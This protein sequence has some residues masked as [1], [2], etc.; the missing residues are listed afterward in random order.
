[1][2]DTLYDLSHQIF[3]E[4]T[5]KKPNEV[6]LELTEKVKFPE[7]HD[8]STLNVIIPKPRV[9]NGK[10]FFEGNVFEDYEKQY[11]SIWSLFL[12]S[13]YHLGAHVA[14]SKYTE[15]ENWLRNKTP[16]IGWKVIDYVE[17]LKVE[18][19]L[20]KEFSSAFNNI[21]SIDLIYSKIY[22]NQISKDSEKRSKENF[23]NFY[24]SKEKDQIS[25][26]KNN[27][28]ENNKG[29]NEITSELEYLYK[30]HHLISNFLYPY[31]EHNHFKNGEFYDEKN[32][33]IMPNGEFQRIVSNL[34]EFWINE[35][36]TRD[37]MLEKY[38]KLSK[39]LNFDDVIINPENFT[40]YL[41]LKNASSLF[42][43]KLSSQ[44]K[45]IT[46]ISDSPT[47]EDLGIM[48]LQKAIQAIAAQNDS[49]QMFEQ[50]DGRRVGEA[51]AIIFDTSA[52]MKLKFDDMKKFALALSETA[53]ELNS[54]TGQWGLFCF[55]NKFMI[56]KDSKEK[57]TQAVKGRI[58]GIENSGLSFIP[59]SITLASR[60]LSETISDR[61]FIFLITDGRS[62]GYDKIDKNFQNSILASRRMG[63]NVIGIGV[64]ET[65]T[66]YFTVSF[67]LADTRKTVA[68]FV[69]CY[70]Q[71]AHSMM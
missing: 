47:P 29:V 24:Y 56:V 16:D 66:K 68:K 27:L 49:I 62:L 48:E 28:Q 37:K 31:R 9:I 42:L 20:K 70:Q 53:E 21:G 1:M 8:V 18:N 38:H 32:I 65:I 23:G 33:V 51:W 10:Y 54:S 15:Y 58:G 71:V 63:I 45:I 11:H 57:Y 30:N 2:K 60:A 35:K 36:I 5:N 61:K 3:Y 52:S 6:F 4:V 25:K 39:D 13:I 19:Y 64:P 50:D 17:D 7:I 34:D 69:E 46:N 59:D 12:A 44:L 43:K 40:E 22:I 41:R 55:N 14:V 67:P 26:I